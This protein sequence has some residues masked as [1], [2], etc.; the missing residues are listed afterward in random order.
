MNMAIWLLPTGAAL[1][2]Y[3]I[4]Q[5]LVKKYIA[6]V[7]PAKFCLYFVAA[8]AIVNLGFYFTEVPPSLFLAEGR[9]FLWVGLL[10]YILDGAAWILYFESIVAGPITIVGTLSAAYPVITVV[11]ARFFLK[12][13]LLITQYVGVATVILGCVGLAYAPFGPAS[14]KIQS[15]WIPLAISA[16]FMWGIAQTLVKYGYRLPN[17][18]EANL[19]LLN[20]LGGLLTLGLYGVLRGSGTS[21]SS[22]EWGLSFLPMGMMAAGDLAVIIASRTGPVSVVTPLSGAYPVVTL[23]FAWIVL[24]ERLTL[25][26]WF[27][28]ILVLSG[29]FLAPGSA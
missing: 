5:G 3:G 23:I 15:K 18:N 16:L 21:H 7:A 27:C 13:N 20:T 24:K 2:L 10:A 4:G 17:A 28:L 22:K 19:A 14:K 25:F 11:F 9:D 8:K 12:E 1:F 26:Q 6:D 29:M